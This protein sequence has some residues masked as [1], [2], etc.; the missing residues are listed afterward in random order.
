MTTD[1]VSKLAVALRHFPVDCLRLLGFR[2]RSRQRFTNDENDI[3]YG[4]LLL[5]RLAKAQ[6]LPRGALLRL[7]TF[8]RLKVVRQ[9]IVTIKVVHVF[10]LVAILAQ[11]FRLVELFVCIRIAKYLD[12]YRF[13]TLTHV[14]LHLVWLALVL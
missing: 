2:R 4:L 5:G 11:F 6:V 8:V 9:I 13:N 12:R 10:V 14:Y 3:S 1:R 7:Y